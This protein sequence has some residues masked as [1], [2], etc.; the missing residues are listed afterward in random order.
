MEAVEWDI[1]L[2]DWKNVDISSAVIASDAND[3]KS[4]GPL[5]THYQI[6]IAFLNKKLIGMFEYLGEYFM[7]FLDD[8]DPFGWQIKYLRVSLLYTGSTFNNIP[9]VIIDLTSV[10]SV[11]ASVVDCQRQ[12]YTEIYVV[13]ESYF[14]SREVIYQQGWAN[15]FIVRNASSTDQ[16]IKFEGYPFNFPPISDAWA[17]YV[18]TEKTITVSYN[19]RSRDRFVF[20]GM[21]NNLFQNRMRSFYQMRSNL[22]NGFRR[23]LKNAS[24]LISS[25]KIDWNEDN[26]IHFEFLCTLEQAR[27]VFENKSL[28][29]SCFDTVRGDLRGPLDFRRECYVASHDKCST[30]QFPHPRYLQKTVI[31]IEQLISIVGS[32]YFFEPIGTGKDDCRESYVSLRRSNPELLLRYDILDGN[33][34]VEGPIEICDDVLGPVDSTVATRILACKLKEYAKA[35]HGISFTLDRRL[36]DGTDKAMVLHAEVW[37]KAA[38]LPKIV[39]WTR[40]VKDEYCVEFWDDQDKSFAYL[41]GQCWNLEDINIVSKRIK[42]TKSRYPSALEVLGG[43]LPPAAQSEMRRRHNEM[44]RLGV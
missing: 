44:M 30:I 40:W 15:M 11:A 34:I 18:E 42:N 4:P 1:D 23:C 10:F 27:W 2:C 14:F 22:A 31:D 9:E 43:E 25:G 5:S 24:S 29:V 21:D 3:N 7:L 17:H 35:L 37:Y 6:G 8:Q 19:R 26:I 38:T 20:D 12:F 16:T 28:F 39:V 33:F 32:F 36:S 13:H 41:Y